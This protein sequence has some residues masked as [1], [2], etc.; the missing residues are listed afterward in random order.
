MLKWFFAALQALF[1]SAQHIYEK[2]EGSGSVHLTNGSGSGRP[3]PNTGF[4]TLFMNVR[5]SVSLWLWPPWLIL[6]WEE[7]A[8]QPGILQ[9]QRDIRGRVVTRLPALSAGNKLIG[10]HQCCGSM[11]FWRVSGSGSADPCFLTN[12]SGSAFGSES[13]FFR[14]WPSRCHQKLIF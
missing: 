13:C 5:S 2:K 14:H 11:T 7:G 1:Q 12:G 10:A 4:F 3:I 9:D 6:G 8:R